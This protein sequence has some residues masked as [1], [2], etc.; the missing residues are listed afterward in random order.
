[1]RVV[2]R[3]IPH[4]GASARKT[5]C[6]VVAER[7]GE[8]VTDGW[9]PPIESA[10]CLSLPALQA[11]GSL[12]PG[13]ATSGA[14]QWTRAGE[15]VA[16]IAYRSELRERDGALILEYSHVARDGKR[17]N[18]RCVVRLSTVPNHYGG[19]NWYMHCPVIGRRARKLYKWPGIAE[20]RHRE[21]VHPKPT[22]AS[23]RVSGCERIIAQRWALRRKLGD[24]LSDL[25]GEPFKPKWMRW[26][27][28][29]KYA[30]RDAE[31]EAQEGRYFAA[32][33]GRLGG[34]S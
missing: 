21:A 6:A 15:R 8:R 26:R 3:A 34:R 12:I 5:P 4:V 14:W 23:Q 20:F 13:T 24:N 2:C 1:M 17:E 18:V 33:L 7:P 28:F 16:S 9:R 19:A 31:L 10:F 30:E 32:L 25:F 27:T 22:Y 11:A 29:E